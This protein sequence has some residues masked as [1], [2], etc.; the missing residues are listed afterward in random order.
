MKK[1]QNNICILILDDEEYIVASLRS[2]LRR[3]P[4]KILTFTI[5][6]E[7]LDTLK[8]ETADI[9]ISDMRM[10]VMSG[11]DFL[12]KARELCPSATRLVLSGYEDKHIVIDTID[13]GIAHRFLMKPWEDQEFIQNIDEIL[14]FRS[15]LAEIHLNE[16]LQNIHTIPTPKGMLDRL[17]KIIHR[18][19]QNI[20]DLVS[21]IEQYPSL[22]VRIMRI[23]NSVYYGARNPITNIFD[24][25]IFIGCEFVESLLL[26]YEISR[27]IP[28]HSSP[29]YEHC[30]ERIWLTSVDR[31]TIGR[32]IAE[33]WD[34]YKDPH[35]A[36]L[37]CL[38]LDIGFYVHLFNDLQTFKKFLTLA[39][40][41]SLPLQE[42][43]QRVY[44]VPHYIIG[45]SLLEFWN[46]PSS[47]VNLVR[48]QYEPCK[49]D[50]LRIILQLAIL[51]QTGSRHI[52][53]DHTIDPLLDVW[54]KKLGMSNIF[55]NNSKEDML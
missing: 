46:F 7:A 26:T 50:P 48:N 5:P 21:D 31:A 27:H 44:D 4:Y 8:F 29:D 36:F 33:Q 49:Y 15:E 47:I 17:Q 19:H 34:G 14:I 55:Q 32:S 12:K 16:L 54:A 38:L 35:T 2:L 28:V 24:A 39:D 53:H 41:L 25:T 1:D 18:K 43:E 22:V 6:Q 52:P 9:I 40:T 45:A 11:I 13:Q 10:P 20:T 37:V 23:A 42:V 51:L 3:K 30:I